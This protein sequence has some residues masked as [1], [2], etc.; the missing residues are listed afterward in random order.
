MT[1][2]NAFVVGGF[3]VYDILDLDLRNSSIRDSGFSINHYVSYRKVN[4]YFGSFNK[5]QK[6]TKVNTNINFGLVTRKIPPSVFAVRYETNF[7]NM[8]AGNYA[9]NLYVRK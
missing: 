7:F 6:A 2:L 1:R 9:S 8:M 5:G 3:Y 4:R